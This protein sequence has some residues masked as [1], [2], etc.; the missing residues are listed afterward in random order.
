ME[1]KSTNL[2]AGSQLLPARP[3]GAVSKGNIMTSTTSTRSRVANHK[4]DALLRDLVPFTNYNASIVATLDYR[5]IYTVTHWGTEIVRYDTTLRACGK[6]A[7]TDLNLRYYSQTTSALQGR[8][9]R[10]LLTR[11]EVLS[12]VDWHSNF[13][14]KPL[15]RRIMRLA[16]IR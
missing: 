7:V 8:I 2:V 10:N 13:G 4:I 1:F 11:Y 9:L 15:A 5:G 14:D 3:R 6:D 16:N 12:F